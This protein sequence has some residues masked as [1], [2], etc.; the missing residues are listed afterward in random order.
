MAIL[1]Y[2]VGLKGKA[3]TYPSDVPQVDRFR[4]DLLDGKITKLRDR[5]RCDVHAN[6]QLAA[7]FAVPDGKIRFCAFTEFKTSL[8]ETFL[9]CIRF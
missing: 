9:A 6:V 1:S 3:V 2:D 7:I 5:A 4:S 8:G